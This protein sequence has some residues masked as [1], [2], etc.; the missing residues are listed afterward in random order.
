MSWDFPW[1]SYELWDRSIWVSQLSKSLKTLLLRRPPISFK[2]YFEVLLGSSESK[3]SILLKKALIEVWRARIRVNGNQVGIY[4]KKERMNVQQ[5]YYGILEAVKLV[6]VSFT[7]YTYDI[8]IITY[9][10]IKHN[11]QLNSGTFPSRTRWSFLLQEK[12][13]GTKINNSGLICSVSEVAILPAPKTWN[14]TASWYEI[15][16][17]HQTHLDSIHHKP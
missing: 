3:R 10:Y 9:L 11:C 16:M 15:S 6:Y 14:K 5:L 12:K 17:H 2:E 4:F 13:L 7:P 1:K 8:H